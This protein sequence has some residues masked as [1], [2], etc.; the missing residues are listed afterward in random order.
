MT[1]ENQNRVDF[2]VAFFCGRG[3]AS[4]RSLRPGRG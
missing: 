4:L 3:E 1:R 2:D